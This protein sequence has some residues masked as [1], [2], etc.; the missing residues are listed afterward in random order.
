[1]LE[2]IRASEDVYET[3]AIRFGLW[4]PERGR[5]AEVAPEIRSKPVK[6][7]VLGCGFGGG[8]GMITLK[9]GL[10]EEEARLAV[11]LYR[12][13]MAKVPELW[14]KYDNGL[15]TARMQL[16]P[17]EVQLPSGRTLRYPNLK[18]HRE[19]FL[20]KV[21]VFENGVRALDEKERM[22]TTTTRLMNSKRVRVPVWGGVVTENAAQALARDVFADRML[23]LKRAGFE[24]FMV[25]HIHDEL[26][27][28]VPEARAEEIFEQAC[29]IMSTSPD[30]IPDLPVAADGKILDVYTK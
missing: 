20:A 19:K 3:F 4:S 6:P 13:K 27:M 9:F 2:E 17:Y 30:W 8:A 25:L 24:D 16:Q 1:M 26:V 12:E 21:P 11:R 23:A 5:L 15:A 7:M 14:G 22:V 18:A 28:E 10:E 29:K